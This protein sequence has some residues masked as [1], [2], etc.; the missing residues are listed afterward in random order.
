MALPYSTSSNLPWG[1]RI[2]TIPAGG[3]QFICDQFTVEQ[4]GKLIERSTHLGA[5]NGAV[6]IRQPYTGSATLQLE[7]T[8]T[9]FANVSMVFSAWVPQENANLNFFITGA[10]APEQTDQFK[11][12]EIQ[13]R[14]VA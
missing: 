2:L 13:I 9:A 11:T 1:T 4:Q 10:S 7:T 14:E 6:L 5:P 8:A 3:S 12:C